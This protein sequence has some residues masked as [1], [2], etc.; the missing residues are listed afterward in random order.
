MKQERRWQARAA[1]VQLLS[2]QLELQKAA[3]LVGV[4]E[5]ATEARVARLRAELKKAADALTQ[6]STQAV[7]GANEMCTPSRR[8]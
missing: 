8:R 5:H 4:R 3:T 7:M 1:G 2:R 6:A